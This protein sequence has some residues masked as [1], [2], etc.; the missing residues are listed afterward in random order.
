MGALEPAWGIRGHTG[1][2]RLLW[3]VEITRKKLMAEDDK[4]NAVNPGAAIA[5]LGCAVGLGCRTRLAHFAPVQGAAAE[6]FPSRTRQRSPG[7]RRAIAGRR[8]GGGESPITRRGY[9]P[10]A[11]ACARRH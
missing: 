4:C 6:R 5:I 3:F 9:W 8:E 7:W 10:E 11:P 1:G 2:G